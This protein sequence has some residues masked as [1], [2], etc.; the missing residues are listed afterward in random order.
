MQKDCYKKTPNI[1][2]IISF[3]KVANM[4][5][6]RRLWPLQNRQFGAEIKNAKKHA[7]SNSFPKGKPF[8]QS[9]RSAVFWLDFER[10]KKWK[11]PSD[12]RL[13]SMDG[14]ETSFKIRQL[15]HDIS[16]NAS[17]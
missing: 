14:S 1:R 3:R 13:I 2:K 17:I 11:I 4:A 9:P 8:A 7:R 6:M 5:T 16:K 12:Y 15:D 10:L